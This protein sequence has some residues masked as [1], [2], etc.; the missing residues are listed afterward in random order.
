ML[1]TRLH[2]RL[3]TWRADVSYAIDANVVEGP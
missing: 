2:D 1:G 3:H